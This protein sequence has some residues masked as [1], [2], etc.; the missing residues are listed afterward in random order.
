[1]KKVAILMYDKVNLQSFASIYAFLHGFDRVS[2]KCYAFKPEITDEF[3]L[4]LHP[5]IHSESLYG[6]DL[7]VVPDGIGALSLRY[8]EIFLSWVK[9]GF[10]AK[11]K[12]GLDLGSL[13]L[14]GAGFLENRS[15]VVRGGYKNALSEY[16]EVIGGEYCEDYGIYSSIGLTQSLKNRLNEILEQDLD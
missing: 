2:V 15:A 5:E 14:G 13:V 12:I 1:M 4:R 6:V 11:V 7:L 9:S 10:S 3:G 16:C 8:D